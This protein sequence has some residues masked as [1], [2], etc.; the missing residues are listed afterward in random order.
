MYARFLRF[1]YRT[2]PVAA[3]R[4]GPD[5]EIPTHR[6][7]QRRKHRRLRQEHVRHSC[8]ALCLP[9]LLPLLVLV[10]FTSC[11]AR[12]APSFLFI[13][14]AFFHAESSVPVAFTAF[15]RVHAPVF[16]QVGRLPLSARQKRAPLGNNSSGAQWLLI[17]SDI[18]ITII[19]LAS[20]RSGTSQSR[21]SKVH[22]LCTDYCVEL[23][24]CNGNNYHTHSTTLSSVRKK[25]SFVVGFA[26]MNFL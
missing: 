16:L 6:I 13:I 1:S 25:L 17:V 5:F 14:T 11:Q 21:T 2:Q 24:S 18:I 22:F 19:D 12:H 20:S 23:C 3:S 7:Q 8:F 15:R 26:R 10:I 4:L 9:L